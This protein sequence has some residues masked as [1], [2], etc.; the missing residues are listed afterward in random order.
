[1]LAGNQVVGVPRSETTLSLRC[2]PPSTPTT[3]YGRGVSSRLQT[4]SC[5]ATHVCSGSTA[6]GSPNLRIGLFLA[7]SDSFPSFSQLQSLILCGVRAESDP[8]PRVAGLSLYPSRL[9]LSHGLYSSCLSTTSPIPETLRSGTPPSMKMIP[10]N[11]SARASFH[12]RVYK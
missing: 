3:S 8:P 4:P 9:F 10:T 6:H 11:T 2:K 7:L 12:H 1:M 5:F